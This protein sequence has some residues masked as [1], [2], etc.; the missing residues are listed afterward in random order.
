MKVY[1]IVSKYYPNA[2]RAN[3]FYM[4]R[5]SFLPLIISKAEDL[6]MLPEFAPWKGK[7][8][9]DYIEMLLP[10]L[11]WEGQEETA[12]S[13]RRRG[14]ILEKTIDSETEYRQFI[15]ALIELSYSQRK[16][17]E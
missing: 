6:Y 3:Y 12:G 4:S 15:D 7:R 17:D 13:Y 14:V 1:E 2:P 10:L 8:P 11:E 16:T 9:L 5:K